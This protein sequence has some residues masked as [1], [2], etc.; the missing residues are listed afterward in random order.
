M[1]STEAARAPVTAPTPSTTTRPGVTGRGP[2]AALATS[3]VRAC[4]ADRE[5]VS[6]VLPARCAPARTPSSKDTEMVSA[7][8]HRDEQSMH[9]CRATTV[10]RPSTPSAGTYQPRTPTFRANS[11]S[12]P[13]CPTF[14]VRRI[15]TVLPLPPHDT[16]RAT[17]RTSLRPTSHARLM[18]IGV[19]RRGARHAPPRKS[20]L[21]P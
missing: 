14:T 5:R 13:A 16:A 19:L 2:G 8:K 17:V 18:G 20:H 10:P 11:K 12:P 7:P 6:P 1:P 4:S 3:R 9:P 15:H 21:T